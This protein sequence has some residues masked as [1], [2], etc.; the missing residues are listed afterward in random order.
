MIALV[1]NKKPILGVSNWPTEKTCLLHKMVKVHLDILRR[2]EKN[3]CNYNWR[4]S[5]CRTIGSRH[6][7]I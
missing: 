3:L 5:K 4:I 2:M 6:H 1:K 7:L